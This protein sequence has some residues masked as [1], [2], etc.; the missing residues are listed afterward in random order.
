MEVWKQFRDTVYSVSNLGNIR[1]DKTHMLLKANSTR[2]GYKRITIWHKQLSY[3]IAVHRMIA[4]V[5]LGNPSGNAN[6]V[7]HIDGDPSNN[8]VSNLEWC[9][10]SANIQHA[11]DTG[12]AKRGEESVSSILSEQEVIEIKIALS[13]NTVRSLARRYGVSDATISHIRNGDTWAHVMPELNSQLSDPEKYHKYKIK[14]TDIPEIRKAFVAGDSDTNIAK[15]YGVHRA[16][17]YNI[18]NGKSWKNY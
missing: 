16:S 3:T 4:E 11:Y 2:Q 9:T 15:R 10:V 13:S 7:N 5:F 18:R 8:R 1:N 17:I 14:A 6:I 12:L